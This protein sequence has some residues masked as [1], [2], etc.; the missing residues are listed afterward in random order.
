MSQSAANMNDHVAG[1][2]LEEEEEEA[3]AVMVQ[4]LLTDEHSAQ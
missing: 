2:A 1:G 3:L 4:E